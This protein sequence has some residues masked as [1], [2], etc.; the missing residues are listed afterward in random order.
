MA[1]DCYNQTKGQ[2]FKIYLTCLNGLVNVARIDFVMAASQ[3]G[4]TDGSSCC[5]DMMKVSICEQELAVEDSFWRE[6]VRICNGV[7]SCQLDDAH[8]P[9][10]PGDFRKSGKCNGT[11]SDIILVSFNCLQPTHDDDE[12]IHFRG[13]NTLFTVYVMS[14]ITHSIYKHSHLMRLLNCLLSFSNIWIK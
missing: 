12:G 3:E 6:I 7:K 8:K 5:P 13:V 2:H 1:Y 4:C 14:I 9:N 10:W 11:N